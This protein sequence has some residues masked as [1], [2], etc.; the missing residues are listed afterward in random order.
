VFFVPNEPSSWTD[1]INE[2]VHTSDDEDIGDIEAVRRNFIVQKKGLVNIH[3][4]SIPLHRFE[5]WEG[6]VVWLKISKQ[7]V[8]T[9][10]ARG[11]GPETPTTII[12]AARLQ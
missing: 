5:G 11:T 7:P 12:I 1:L 10:F 6:K 3:Q 9:N 2:S 8:K 4:Y